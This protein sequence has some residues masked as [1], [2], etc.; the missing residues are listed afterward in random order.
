MPPPAN[1]DGTIGHPRTRPRFRFG[2]GGVTIADR[3]EG[4]I[5]LTSLDVVTGEVR[6]E[7]SVS[8]TPLA[9]SSD[10][11]ILSNVNDAVVLS[12]LLGSRADWLPR[13]GCSTTTGEFDDRGRVVLALVCDG[14]VEIAVLD[15]ELDELSTTRVNGSADSFDFATPI[16]DYTVLGTSQYGDFTVV[17]D[18]HVLRSYEALS[19]SRVF[20]VGDALHVWLYGGAPLRLGPSGD[21]VVGPGPAS[22]RVEPQRRAEFPLTTYEL[23]SDLSTSGIALTRVGYDVVDWAISRDGSST[24]EVIGAE[25]STL[26]SVRYGESWSTPTDRPLELAQADAGGYTFEVQSGAETETMLVSYTGEVPD[27]SIGMITVYRVP[28]ASDLA[29]GLESI[30]ARVPES[31]I[32]ASGENWFADAG[33]LGYKDNEVW[34]AVERCLYW[35]Y[36]IDGESLPN[37]SLLNELAR[38]QLVKGCS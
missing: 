6:W 7:R 11:W 34:L 28:N 13:D 30:R 23:Y 37:Q 25:D 17:R 4:G 31:R 12:D 32:V 24:F 2:W 27:A 29:T 35:I 1:T 38:G 16:G 14:D 21:P 5:E 15:S 18:G 22:A 3:V 33:Y 8:R 19:P 10:G 36:E 9:V 20:Q 26:R